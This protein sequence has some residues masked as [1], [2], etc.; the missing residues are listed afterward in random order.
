MAVKK[1]RRR[2][3]KHAHDHQE[4]MRR[5]A[6]LERQ[7]FLDSA[8]K[9]NGNGGGVLRVEAADV[10]RAEALDEAGGGA[11]PWAVLGVILTVSITFIAIVTYLIATGE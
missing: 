10:R 11:N 2:R 1:N 8:T 4:T 9:A 3:R 5:L 7:S 6:P